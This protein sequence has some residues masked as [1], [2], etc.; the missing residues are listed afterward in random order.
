M[1]AILFQDAAMKKK[2]DAIVKNKPGYSDAIAVIQAIAIKCVENI[3][4][5]EMVESKLER[6]SDIAQKSNPID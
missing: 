5:N 2:Y 3:N 6:R 1:K 4:D